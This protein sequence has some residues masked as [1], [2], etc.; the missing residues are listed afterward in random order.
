MKTND[1]AINTPG[2]SYRANEGP[3][4]EHCDWELG[5]QTSR[6]LSEVLSDA[7]FKRGFAE[8]TWEMTISPPD[9]LDA[10]AAFEDRAASY[11][12]FRA[13]ADGDA[14][15]LWDSDSHSLIFVSPSSS[16]DD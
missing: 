3:E 8:L 9:L 14:R 7:H 11:L 16:D 4:C 6:E 10:I 5:S 15:L 12:E 2:P 1:D 13:W